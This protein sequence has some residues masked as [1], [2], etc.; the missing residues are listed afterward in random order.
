MMVESYARLIREFP[1]ADQAAIKLPTLL[2]EI[3]ALSAPVKPRGAEMQ[4][5]ADHPRV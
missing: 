4:Y 2:P 5:I 1:E 3:R